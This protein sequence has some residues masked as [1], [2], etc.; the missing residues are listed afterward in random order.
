M[1]ERIDNLAGLSQTRPFMAACL[2]IMMFSLAGIPPMAGFLRQII[3]LP[4]GH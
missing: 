3:R 2:A 1:V 4:R